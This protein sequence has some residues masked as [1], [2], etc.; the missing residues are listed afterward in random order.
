MACHNQKYWFLESLSSK[1]IF[2]HAVLKTLYPCFFL[3]SLLWFYA[4]CTFLRHFLSTSWHLELVAFW[5][6]STLRSHNHWSSLQSRSLFSFIY[7]PS[8]NILACWQ[9]EIH[10]R[11]PQHWPAGH[12]TER[13]HEQSQE[14]VRR[15][16]LRK[17]ICFFISHIM[18]I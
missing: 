16:K 3:F 14:E 7:L 12:T 1:I 17:W 5:L 11:R 8:Y 15:F 2:L 13:R 9:E 18:T 4:F 10:L 6:N